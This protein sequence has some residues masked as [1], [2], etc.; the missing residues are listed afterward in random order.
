M[1]KQALASPEASFHEALARAS[2]N[3]LIA[4]TGGEDQRAIKLALRAF[5]IASY[6]ANQYPATPQQ[7]PHLGIMELTQSALLQAQ[8]DL[9]LAN[10]KSPVAAVTIP[11]AQEKMAR[12]ALADCTNVARMAITQTKM[13]P[14]SE[15][16]QTPERKLPYVVNYFANEDG[17][18]VERRIERLVE[19]IVDRDFVIPG[20]ALL[21]TQTS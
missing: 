11:S 3:F 12:G 20:L 16:D 7:F 21:A 13:H 5:H 8:E 10:P 19:A 1:L 2:E 17:P 18:P 14:E 15:H 4:V 9:L 6:Y